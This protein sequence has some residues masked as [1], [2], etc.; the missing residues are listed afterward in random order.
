[1]TPL[2]GAAS[3]TGGTPLGNKP[4]ATRSS[5]E[6]VE[7]ERD[8]LRAELAAQREIV[9]T[10]TDRLRS[11]EQLAGAIRNARIYRCLRLLGRWKGVDRTLTFCSSLP[12]HR[13]PAP[14]R[15][16]L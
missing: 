9:R 1:M 6:E 4:G 5:I 14:R 12:L 3:V 8:T 10:T 15:P 7:A 2:T 13:R 16:T 11:F